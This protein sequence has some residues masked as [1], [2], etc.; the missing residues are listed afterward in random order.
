M[1]PSLILERAGDQ[2]PGKT[3]SQGAEGTLN[4]NDQATGR[5]GCPGYTSNQWSPMQTRFHSQPQ[6]QHHSSL[7]WGCGHF[8]CMQPPVGGRKQRCGGF[9]A[10]TWKTRIPKPTRQPGHYF[11]MLLTWHGQFHKTGTGIAYYYYYYYFEME[12]CS[13][14]PGWRAVVQSQLTATSAS[15][16]QASVQWCDLSSPQPPPPE[17]KQF[18]CLS[19]L[20]GHSNHEK[21]SLRRAVNIVAP[22]S[23]SSIRLNESVEVPEQPEGKFKEQHTLIIQGMEPESH[24]PEMEGKKFL[25]IGGDYRRKCQGL[26][27]A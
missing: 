8:M 25:E 26:A 24:L 5:P 23:N 17:L 22:A 19:L 21:S 6:F 15:R 2:E 4:P 7:H 10:N 16:V 3:S 20:N 18:F 14:P 11:L 12:F 1:V 9:T 13:H 27:C